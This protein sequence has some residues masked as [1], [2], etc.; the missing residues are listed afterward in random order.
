M[1]LA[2]ALQDALWLVFL[3]VFTLSIYTWSK[4]KVANATAAVLV[5]LFIIYLIFFRFPK[6]VWL[7]AIFVI[8]YWIYGSDFKKMLQVKK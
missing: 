8:I 3:I 6:L 5:T 4:S 2:T 1:L 7:V